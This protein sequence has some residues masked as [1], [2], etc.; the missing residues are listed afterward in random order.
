MTN[1]SIYREQ[2]REN[3]RKG[4]QFEKEVFQCLKN[5][6]YNVDQQVECKGR[7]KADIVIYTKKDLASAVIDCK[8]KE[9]LQKKDIDQVDRY[10][11]DLRV[12]KKWIFMV[13][14]TQYSSD[15]EDYAKEK[16]V[17][18]HQFENCNF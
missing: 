8:N 11:K 13:R 15:V 17:K 6:G 7:T 16:G 14:R 10:G 9:R 18:L 1:F 4:K 5:K 2:G 12:G 3:A